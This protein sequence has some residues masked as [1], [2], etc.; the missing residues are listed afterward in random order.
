MLPRMKY[1][2][3]VLLDQDIETVLFHLG[4]AHSLQLVQK[5][6][7]A[8]EEDENAALLARLQEA[9]VFLGVQ[10]LD[11]LPAATRLPSDSDLRAARDLAERSRE[12][13]EL[14][15]RKR[16]QCLDAEQAEA[17]LRGY[18]PLGEAFSDLTHGTYLHARVGRLP[19]AAMKSAPELLGE[20]VLVLPLDEQG[21]AAFFTT[22]ERQAALDKGLQALEFTP[23]PIPQPPVGGTPGDLW[24][25]AA[26]RT[27][28]LKAELADLE[29]RRLALAGLARD[30]LHL[31]LA[32]L[33]L[34][35]Q[36]G[37][38]RSG[39]SVR[40][41][42]CVLEGWIPQPLLAPLIDNLR[43]VTQGRLAADS[44]EP[45]ELPQGASDLG[46]VPVLL[47]HGRVLSGFERLILSYGAP[48]YGSADPTPLAAV[49]F[50]FLF[51]L[52]FGDVGQGALILGLGIL[53]SSGLAGRLLPLARRWT[54][55]APFF[56]SAGAASVVMG[57]AYGS[58]FGDE[59]LLIPLTR[60]VSG[61]F[62]TSVDRFVS[63]L[64]TDGF[65]GLLTFFA[66]S[67]AVG[68]ALNSAALILNIFNQIRLGHWKGA[69]YGKTGLAGAIFYWYALYLALSAF[70]RGSLSLGEWAGVLVPLLLMSAGPALHRRLFHGETN[71]GD[72]NTGAETE[73]FHGP[74]LL[75]F[76]MEVLEVFS[77]YFSNT[78]SFLRVGAFALAHA[79]MGLIVH[80]LGSLIAQSSAVG[81][82][83]AFLVSA[84]GNL[85]ILTLEALI[86]VVQVIRLQYYEIF[87]KFFSE[88]GM[89]FRPFR[90]TYKGGPP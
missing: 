84:M 71:P 67:L 65:A 73:N 61:W 16:E 10:D 83:L 47:S 42:L 32:A 59:R 28:G 86:V 12:L 48:V 54:G 50:V 27:R 31:F 69:L 78:L 19:A 75:L 14:T 17:E 87:S 7:Q 15:I 33:S 8:P 26:E 52:M 2:R 20:E 40:G 81:P 24:R 13:M 3:L 66:F 21:H 30:Q 34:L 46:P 45:D 85:L 35:V 74:W 49:S 89:F 68:I 41:R 64:P 63:I 11:E 72:T 58:V 9:R 36:I 82:V 57:L 88:T 22:K 62:G 29:T 37:R 6:D 77:T 70:L 23:A 43:Q 55:N 56:L 5:P 76:P 90:F 79:V 1:L 4:R 18:E 44:R 38:A 53:L 60:E 51:A 39:L 25:A 80:T